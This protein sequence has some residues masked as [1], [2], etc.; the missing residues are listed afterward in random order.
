MAT[1]LNLA[2]AGVD[3]SMVCRLW[4]VGLGGRLLFLVGIL[5]VRYCI[6]YELFRLKTIISTIHTRP[7][8]VIF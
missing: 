7:E 4:L 6:L 5:S 8:S 3:G 1:I 2:N